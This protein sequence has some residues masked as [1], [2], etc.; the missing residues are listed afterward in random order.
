VTFTYNQQPE[1]FKA[2][3]DACGLVPVAGLFS[4]S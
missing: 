1:S 3:L 4:D 2:A